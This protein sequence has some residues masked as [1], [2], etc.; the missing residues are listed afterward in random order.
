MLQIRGYVIVRETGVGIPNL[1]VTAFDSGGAPEI[2]RKQKPTAEVMKHLGR[3]ISTVFT[4]EQGV[5]SISTEDLEFTGNEPRP[6]LV[7][8]VFAPEDIDDPAHPYPAPP[9]DRVLYMSLARID[10]G[11]QEAFPIRL[12]LSVLRK[13]RIESSRGYV[14]SLDAQW[15]A[16][17]AITNRLLQ[18]HRFLLESKAD[19]RKEAVEKTRNLHG[20]PVAQRKSPFLVVGKANL[21][22]ME[23]GADGKV[24]RIE[25]LQHKSVAEGLKNLKNA[26]SK[27]TMRLYLTRE[28][29]TQ[30]GIKLENGKFSG[31]PKQKEV[32]SLMLSLTGGVDLIRTRGFENPNPDEL[33]AKYLKPV[34]SRESRVE[35][36][37]GGTYEEEE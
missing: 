24:T 29:L 37:N 6:D 10:V 22:R 2:I 17:D 23:D 25:T 11:A 31:N 26:K 35:A 20:V 4:D 16:Q 7:I 36:Y 14:N 19:A 13:K 8:V 18:R 27:R 30:L 3:R 12:S 33:E 1:V 9:E 21:S 28:N 34:A 15:D 32:K 5:F